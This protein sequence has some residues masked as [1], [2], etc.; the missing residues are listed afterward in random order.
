M[1]F[2]SREVLGLSIAEFWRMTPAVYHA[3]LME[4]VIWRSSDT[5]APP[6]RRVEFADEIGW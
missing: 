5:A 6:V 4:A 3:L 1:M 2:L